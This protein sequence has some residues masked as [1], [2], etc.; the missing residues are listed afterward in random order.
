MHDFP[1]LLCTSRYL[2]AAHHNY[3]EPAHARFYSDSYTQKMAI[4][5]PA[6][7][8]AAVGL[9]LILQTCWAQQ[10]YVFA[11]KCLMQP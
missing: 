11:G 3:P 9:F 2:V 8:A 6:M 10:G 1:W 4:S 7:W 5:Q